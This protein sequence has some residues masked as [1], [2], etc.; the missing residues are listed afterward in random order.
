ML[1]PHR[2]KQSKYTGRDQDQRWSLLPNRPRYLAGGPLTRGL[3][4]LWREYALRRSGKDFTHD[5]YTSQETLILT[6][7]PCWKEL[8]LEK[9]C[10]QIEKLV[11]EIL[12]EAKQ[13]RA[14]TGI[15]PLGAEQACRQNPETRPRRAEA[16]IASASL[17]A[18]LS[19]RT[20][21]G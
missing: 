9:Y 8:S 14:K 10:Q 3:V 5:D 21:S 2:A 19:A 17:L 16:G 6:A 13:R 20:A 4:P 7:P 18:P 1:S 11:R 12:R 15:E